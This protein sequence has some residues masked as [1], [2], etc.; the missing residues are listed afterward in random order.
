MKVTDLRRKLAVTLTAVGLLAPGALYAANLNTNLVVNPGFENS[1]PEFG[2]EPTSNT[3]LIHDWIGTPG[4]AYSHQPDVTTV[5][6]YA[7]GGPLAGGGL[8]YFY[9]GANGNDTIEEA[10]TQDIDVSAGPTGSLIAS[11]GATF[12]LSAYFSTYLTQADRG[13]VQADFLNGATVLGTALVTPPTA[14]ALSTWT[15]FV[16]SGLI[17]VG[18]Q[19]VRISSYGAADS[20]GSDGY[21]DNIDFRVTSAVVEPAL[22]VTID[23][24]NGSMILSNLTGAAV[25]ISAYSITSAFE[26]LEPANWRSITDNYDAGSPGPNQVDA[27]HSWTELTDPNA[28]GDLTEQEPSAVGASL[29]NGRS[30]NLSNGGAWIKN[31]V[32]DLVFSYTSGGQVLPGI[33][34]FVDNGGAPFAVGDLNADGAFNA[35]DWT[36]LRTN[37]HTSLSGKSLAEAY[38]L[39]DLT[40]DEMNNHPDFVAFKNL[41]DAANGVGSFAAMVASVPEPS[42]FVLLAAA[43]LFARPLGRFRA[44]ES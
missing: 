5:P 2:P 41:Y 27:A 10:L 25:N 24:D 15:P 17:P 32:E 37:Q 44:D 16:K 13:I 9:P 7:N 19:T 1:G 14:P 20:G 18:T 29:A 31:P 38:R 8:Y 33:L 22:R 6:D 40:G 11:G 23:R 36:I 3:I 12:N 4:F 26:G 43:G 28:N 39:G 42:T 30:V 34:T 21:T 35:A